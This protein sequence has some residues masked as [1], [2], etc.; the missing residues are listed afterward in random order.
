MVESGHKHPYVTAVVAQPGQTVEGA[1]QLSS[2]VFLRT[3]AENFKVRKSEK[4]S[5]KVRKVEGKPCR[6]HLEYMGLLLQL[7]GWH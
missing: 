3:A 7:T 1:D 5:R 6:G 2:R 4:R